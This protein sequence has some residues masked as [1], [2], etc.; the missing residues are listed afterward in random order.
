MV[1]HLLSPIADYILT[2]FT[3]VITFEREVQLIWVRIGLSFLS[4]CTSHLND[5]SQKQRWSTG[6]V[7]FLLVGFCLSD[8]KSRSLQLLGSLSD[9]SCTLRPT[10]DAMLWNDKHLQHVQRHGGHRGAAHHEMGTVSCADTT[11][12]KDILIPT[13]TALGHMTR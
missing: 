12:V 2:I 5:I 13:F 11:S 9:N 3:T 7:I 1:R 6:K 8:R 4:S 10:I